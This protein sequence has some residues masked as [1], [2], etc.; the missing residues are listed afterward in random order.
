MKHNDLTTLKK[1]VLAS[2]AKFIAVTGGVC[3]SI[4]KGVLIS[5]LGVLLKKSGYS[6]AVVKW[7]PYLNVDPGTMSPLEHGEVFVTADGAET[8][9]DL[10]HYERLIGTHLTRKSSVSSGQIFEEILQGERE[11]QFLGRCIQLV[12]HVVDA[13]KRRLLEFALDQ[14]VDFVLIEIG[15]TVGDMEGN[16]FLETLR[17]LRMELGVARFMLSHLS[18]VPFLSWTGEVKTKLTQH[19]VNTLKSL[20][21]VPDCLFLRA[22]NVIDEKAI[23]KLSVMCGISSEYVF[24]VLTHKP[25]YRLFDALNIQ[26]VVLKIQDYFGIQSYRKPDLSEWL[27]FIEMI[28]QSTAEV[29]IGMVAKYVGSNDPYISVIEALRAAGYRNKRTVKIEIIEADQL[30]QEGYGSTGPAWQQLKKVAGILVPGGF[31]K[32]GIEGKIMAVRWAREQKI[33][34]LGLCLGMQV[35]VIE[36]ARALLGLVDANSTEFCKTTASP[37]IAILEEQLGIKAKG[38]TMRLGSFPCKL[39]KGTKAHTAYQQDEVTERHR[40]RYEVNNAYR[41]DFEK[42]GV[43]FSGIYKEKDLVEIAELQDHPFMVGCQFHPEFESAP[44]RV[45]PLFNAFVQAAIKQG[46]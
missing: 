30:E 18:Y 44:L 16:I 35:L 23:N 20:G 22:N 11:G 43:V 26:N 10:G 27:N 14:K 15:G 41:A 39:V 21:L 32:R 25:L 29:T 46:K 38:G 9:L 40:H 4:G 13:T 8:D 6:V 5:S 33:P 36:A 28:E 34:Y 42:N 31:D 3:S 24:Q 12:P 19:S 2:T 7:D 17:Q 45:H 37:V 1:E